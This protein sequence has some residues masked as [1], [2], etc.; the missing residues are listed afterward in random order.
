MTETRTGGRAAAE[1]RE[2]E[3][4]LQTRTPRHSDNS[5]EDR[6]KKV[7]ADRDEWRGSGVCGNCHTD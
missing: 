1:Q 6:S 5:S 3:R 4:M 2:Q 7:P